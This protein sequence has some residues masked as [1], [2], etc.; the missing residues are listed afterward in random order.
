MGNGAGQDVAGDQGVQVLCLA[1]PLGLG[2]GEQV[3]R[4]AVLIGLQSL[5][6]KTGGPPH[7]RQ[8]G[9][10]PHGTALGPVGALGKGHNGF[11]A[12]QLKAEL[13]ARVKGQRGALQ[14]F[15]VCHG[16]A[17][18][19]GGKAAGAAVAA[20]GSERLHH[21]SFLFLSLF[22][23]C[24]PA[25]AGGVIPLYA[26]GCADIC[27]LYAFGLYYI[28]MRRVLHRRRTAHGLYHFVQAGGN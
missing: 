28:C 11:D 14:N 8:H 25:Y 10:V 15:T 19:G 23:A 13:S 27:I 16:G 9:N 20:F 17:Q 3:V 4:L 24:G 21:L 26:P 7:P 5:N 12:A 18:L 1:H 6:D 22:F 2:P